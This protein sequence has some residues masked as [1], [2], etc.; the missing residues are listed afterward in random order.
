MLYLCSKYLNASIVL[1]DLQKQV[2]AISNCTYHMNDL[3]RSGFGGGY[4]L[5]IVTS[6]FDWLRLPQI[7]CLHAWKIIKILQQKKNASTQRTKLYNLPSRVKIKPLTNAIDF[8]ELFLLE[9]IIMLYLPKCTSL[10]VHLPVVLCL[11]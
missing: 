8:K 10:G 6:P 7:W 2:S 4:C 5:K 1:M 9:L 3:I 11:T